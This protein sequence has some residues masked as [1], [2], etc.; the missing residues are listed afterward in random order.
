M[1]TPGIPY[2]FE[3]PLVTMTRSLMPQ[4]DLVRGR[5]ISAPR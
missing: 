1:R 2:A 3:R 4:N 5:S